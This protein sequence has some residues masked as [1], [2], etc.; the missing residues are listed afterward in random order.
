[1]SFESLGLSAP[2]LQAVTEKGYTTLVLH[3]EATPGH[4]SMPP[5]DTAIGMM[6][7]ALARLEAEWSGKLLLVTQNVDDLHERGG[8]RRVLLL[9]LAAIAVV[10]LI[11]CSNLANLGLTRTLARLRDA[12]RPT[13]VLARLGGDEFA[14]L[15]TELPDR[16]AAVE[17]S[18]RKPQAPP[19]RTIL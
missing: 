13:D 15:I 12:L 5:R 4:S 8:S 17:L 10:L 11:A 2:V 18:P 14:V 16:G 3:A 1:M 19:M 9:L 7:V 6:A